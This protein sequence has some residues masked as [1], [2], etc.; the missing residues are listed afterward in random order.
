LKKILSQTAD[1]KADPKDV[2]I[3]QSRLLNYKIKSHHFTV[4]QMK[5]KG[6]Y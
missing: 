4:L 1:Q 5:N 2:I 3:K 6:Q